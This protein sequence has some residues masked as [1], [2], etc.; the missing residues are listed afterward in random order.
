MGDLAYVNSFTL[1]AGRKYN[2]LKVVLLV[3]LREHVGVEELDHFVVPEGLLD[4]Q[5]VALFQQ[6][7]DFLDLTLVVA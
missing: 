3:A 1:L 2:L 7:E 6:V 5:V 4:D